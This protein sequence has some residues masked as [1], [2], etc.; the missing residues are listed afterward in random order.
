[1]LK[2]S[3]STPQFFDIITNSLLECFEVNP[4]EYLCCLQT[5]SFVYYEMGKAH[6]QIKIMAMQRGPII[7]N[8][9]LVLLDKH[10]K[11]QNDIDV[12]LVKDLA[13]F[14]N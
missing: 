10:A 11:H 12:D 7:A 6:D 4:N 5:M 8:N 3:L 9:I 14:V 13:S 2:E 1:M